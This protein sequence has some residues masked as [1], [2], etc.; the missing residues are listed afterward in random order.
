MPSAAPERVRLWMASTRM[1]TRRASIMTFV[2]RSNPFSRPKL[3]TRKPT[4]TTAT[5][6]TPISRGEES[7]WPKTALTSSVAI[8]LWKEPKAKRPK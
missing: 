1:R 2:T 5:A 8:P 6:R 7:I 4:M 3:H